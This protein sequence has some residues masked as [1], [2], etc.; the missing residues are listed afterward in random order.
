ME[1][2]ESLKTQIL[3]SIKT[4]DDI[5]TLEDIRISSMGKKGSITEQMKGLGAL[6]LEQ[7]IEMGK[8][9]NIIKNQIEQALSEQKQFLET[10]EL[11]EK[12]K[13][14]TLDITLPVRP[15]VQGRIHPV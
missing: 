5:K 9:L 1:D 4:A 10:K 7:K 13:K 2:L 6:P 8:K 11:N 12:L 3:N 14:E 15:E